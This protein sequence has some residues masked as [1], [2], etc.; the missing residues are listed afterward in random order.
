MILNTPSKTCLTV[1][2]V[3]VALR[4]C[5]LL[6]LHFLQ[7]LDL[8]LP[9]ANHRQAPSHLASV[10]RHGAHRPRGSGVHV[11]DAPPVQTAIILL[12]TD[13]HGPQY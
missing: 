12:D 1:D 7:D 6:L 3:L 2:L 13:R 8:H 5:L 11:L 10:H 4:D 9:D